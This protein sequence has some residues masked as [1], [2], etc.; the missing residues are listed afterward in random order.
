MNLQLF[1]LE[2]RQGANHEEVGAIGKE[3]LGYQVPPQIGIQEEDRIRGKVPMQARM[4]NWPKRRA[5]T[6]P[7]PTPKFSL[8]ELHRY[9]KIGYGKLSE[10]FGADIQPFMYIPHGD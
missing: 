5:K 1:I 10:E 7:S 6:S 9:R 4:F 2:A 3:R 8:M